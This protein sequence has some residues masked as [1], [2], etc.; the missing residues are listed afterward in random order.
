MFLLFK[1]VNV[2]IPKNVENKE[3]PRCKKQPNNA[4]LKRS[5]CIATTISALKVLNVVNPPKKPVIINSFHSGDSEVFEEK[6]AIAIPIKYP[7]IIF[8]LN[9]P[10]GIAE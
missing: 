7:P 9:V 10:S 2:I 1:K 6:N 3:P 4:S 5:S 8:A